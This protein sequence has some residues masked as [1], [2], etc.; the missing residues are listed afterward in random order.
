MLD[1]S[2]G[3]TERTAGIRGSIEL[4]F[5]P[6]SRHFFFA[7]LSSS[8]VSFLASIAEERIPFFRPRRRG[9]GIAEREESRVRAETKRR[10]E[11]IDKITYLP[12]KSPFVLASTAPCIAARPA[13]SGPRSF[14]TSPSLVKGCY[15]AI[16]DT[17]ET[18]L[19]S[20]TA[21]PHSAPLL[22]LPIGR[23]NV[24][25]RVPG[26]QP[27]EEERGRRRGR[28]GTARRA[29]LDT[30]TLRG[31]KGGNDARGNDPLPPSDRIY[32]R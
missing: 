29:L 8:G 14:I 26:I 7:R 10:G 15:L 25:V 30:T 21:L 5:L 6:R 2:V 11:E 20:R 12:R 24:F 31:A 17:V 3:E 23:K 28:G 18:V 1:L 22:T 9:H 19:R 16:V 27:R 32:S 4:L 13:R